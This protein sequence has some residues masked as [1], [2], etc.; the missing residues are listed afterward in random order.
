MSEKPQIPEKEQKLF[1]SKD[2]KKISPKS[3]NNSLNEEQNSEN[4]KEENI[5]IE[6]NNINNNELT[7]KNE[8]NN[9]NINI[10]ENYNKKEGGG[11]MITELLNVNE[12]KEENLKNKYL[13]E[14]YPQVNNSSNLQKA[15]KLS[16]KKTHEDMKKKIY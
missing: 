13:K 3:N 9:E 6:K 4:K 7:M 12:N 10:K 2:Q 14:K 15:I 1:S 5:L 16:L 8:G 11:F